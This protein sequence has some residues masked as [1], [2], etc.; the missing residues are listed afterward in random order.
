[1]QFFLHVR[2]CLAANI[3]QA[4]ARVELSHVAADLEFSAFSIGRAVHVNKIEVQRGEP[5]EPAVFA[6]VFPAFHFAVDASN[7]TC[8]DVTA[9]R[10]LKVA[11]LI[12]RGERTEMALAVQRENCRRAASAKL[13]DS[14]RLFAVEN[15]PQLQQLHRVQLNIIPDRPHAA[16]CPMLVAILR[17]S[18]QRPAQ[19]LRGSA[20]LLDK[21]PCDDSR[22]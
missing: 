3:E 6:E 19:H 1:M 15:S 22:V 9:H 10:R 21:E 17:D 13:K 5:I 7:L 12:N 8:P 2:H 20:A 18:W 14:L 16:G 4:Q 11:V